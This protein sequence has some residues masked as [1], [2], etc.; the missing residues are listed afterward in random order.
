MLLTTLVGLGVAGIVFG[1]DSPDEVSPPEASGYGGAQDAFYAPKPV[2]GASQ[3]NGQ[4]YNPKSQDE[5]RREDYQGQVFEEANDR[6]PSG[7]EP[8][9]IYRDDHDGM[10]RALGGRSNDQRGMRGRFGGGGR[11]GNGLASGLS[12]RDD[13]LP[14]AIADLRWDARIQQL[15]QALKEA[16][17]EQ[18]DEIAVELRQQLSKL[19]D[20]RTAAREAQI[21]QLEERIQN[22]RDQ[23]NKRVEVKDEIIE[24]RLQT[25][26]NEANG[27]TF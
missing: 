3:D 7:R 8:D 12:R 10:R 18:R 5:E 11:S 24:L 16:P 21:Q 27:R 13:D 14:R 9:S 20:V 1:Q 19:F 17:V 15:T 4:T 2:S 6:L 22:L 23:L 25:L 26:V